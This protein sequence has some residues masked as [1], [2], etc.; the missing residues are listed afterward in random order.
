[1]IETIYVKISG[2]F[3]PV[4]IC[5]PHLSV[6][7]ILAIVV[8]NSLPFVPCYWGFLSCHTR[9][10]L[11]YWCFVSSWRCCVCVLCQWSCWKRQCPVRWWRESRATVAAPVFVFWLDQT[12]KQTNEPFS[13]VKPTRKL[14][15]VGNLRWL[16]SN[17]CVILQRSCWYTLLIYCSSQ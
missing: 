16:C 4:Y 6:G 5:Y 2:F 11:D 13:L 14:S 15:V 7:A 8:H 9:L 3:V 1:M 17:T 12:N 10:C